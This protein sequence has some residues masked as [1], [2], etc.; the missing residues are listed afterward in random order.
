MMH[1]LALFL[2]WGLAVPLIAQPRLSLVHASSGSVTIQDGDERRVAYWSLDPRARPD[3]YVANRTRSVKEVRFITDQDSISF[4]L[5]PGQHH[6]FIILLN[7]K[8][9]C[10]TRLRSAIPA[11]D[12]E[13]R[14]AQQQV[15]RSDTLPFTLGPQNSV[16]VRAVLNARDTLQLMFHSAVTGVYVTQAALAS[17]TTLRATGKDHVQSWGGNAEAIQSDHNVLRLGS[18]E[19][20]SLQVTID[21][22]S[23]AGS[24]GK[25]G[26]D[27]FADRVLE[28]DYDRHIFIVHTRLP[29]DLDGWTELPMDYRGSNFYVPGS[30]ELGGHAYTDRFLFHT[31]YGG[32]LI[33]GA[34]FMEGHGLY[35]HVDT[36]GVETLKDAYGNE[37]HNL[38]T[39]VSSIAV[40]NTRFTQVPASVMDRKAQWPMSIFGNDLLKRFN[41]IIDFPNDV[42][43]L[44]PNNGVLAPFPKGS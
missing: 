42:I 10:Y 4:T 12:R 18:L 25:F 40:A 8:D 28:L 23:G 26:Y 7:G 21:A 14:I 29:H 32:D 6:D 41:V 34:G 17:A 22:H 19:W 30:V 3:V 27:L 2:L 16:L 39:K 38:T 31:G 5:E 37:L 15:Q 1:R 36:V 9:S 33:L 20:D 11:D 24:D 13:R 43:L 35:G 44:K